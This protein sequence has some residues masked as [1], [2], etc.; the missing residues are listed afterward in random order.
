MYTCAA[1]LCATAFAGS[2]ADTAEATAWFPFPA[3]VAD[4]WP[5]DEGPIL[6]PRNVR[7]EGYSL[8]AN[9]AV[10]ANDRDALERLASY[11]ARGPLATKRLSQLADGRLAYALKRPWRDGTVAIAQTKREL[12]ERLAAQVPRPREHLTR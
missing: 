7:L 8:H 3:K 2:G 1:A 4:A 5:G 12:L 9:V 11:L 10:H 6:G